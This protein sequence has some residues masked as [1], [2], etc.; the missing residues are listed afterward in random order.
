MAWTSAEVQGTTKKKAQRNEKKCFLSKLTLVEGQSK[1]FFQKKT[2]KKGKN[3][4]ERNAFLA[5]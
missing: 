3:K 5:I 1:I 4:N 2:L